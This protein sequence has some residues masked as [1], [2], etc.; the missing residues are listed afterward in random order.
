M[1]EL[2]L[3]VNEEIKEDGCYTA[4]KMASLPKRWTVMGLKQK[5]QQLGGTY[6]GL[7]ADRAL[8]A[9]DKPGTGSSRE[10]KD[11]FD[12]RL[13][14]VSYEYEW[15]P[16]FHEIFADCARYDAGVGECTMAVIDDIEEASYE[17]LM[18]DIGPVMNS[19]SQ[20][21]LA[22][23]PRELEGNVD[24][25]V[26][27]KAGQTTQKKFVASKQAKGR[28]KEGA[29][30]VEIEPF[31]LSGKA[32]AVAKSNATIKLTMLQE[33]ALQKAK[34]SR[35]R[36]QERAKVKRELLDVE[37]ASRALAR[38]DI[39]NA[40]IVSE[41]KKRTAQMRDHYMQ[42]GMSPISATNKAKM[43]EKLLND[44]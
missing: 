43:A 42:V 21:L 12:Q 28:V 17:E 11:A 34:D 40:R 27:A 9:R 25:P 23:P 31:K 3:G 22:T 32:L 35:E 4:K 8:N 39:I 37:I 10:E 20:D 24:V 5:F 15:F 29:D 16:V 18:D 1:N 7:K 2:T 44:N 33:I 13:E 41:S 38:Q 6:K 19:P 30:E 14:E 36:V 26:V